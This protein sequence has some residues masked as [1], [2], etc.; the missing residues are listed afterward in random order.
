MSNIVLLPLNKYFHSR[1]EENILNYF[2]N[3]QID[4]IY[5]G[6]I[7]TGLMIIFFISKKVEYLTFKYILKIK[8]ESL[9]KNI[10]HIGNKI[11]YALIITVY[12]TMG[13]ISIIF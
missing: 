1:S 8:N 3:I 7:T 10:S 9:I 11:S 2:S 13:I 12:V 5:I 4:L 6:L